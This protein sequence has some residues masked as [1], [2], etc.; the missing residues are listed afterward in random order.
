MVGPPPPS[1]D[2]PLPSFPQSTSSSL[3]PGTAQ[4]STENTLSDK[5]GTTE[6]ISPALGKYVMWALG[7]YVCPVFASR[8]LNVS[9]KYFWTD[10]LDQ[11]M[12][13]QGFG[14]YI[15]WVLQQSNPTRSRIVDSKC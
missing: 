12:S 11:N 15:N 2:P 1:K 10:S 8:L 3:L 14:I 13:D 4:V 5:C 7:A 6:K 9:A